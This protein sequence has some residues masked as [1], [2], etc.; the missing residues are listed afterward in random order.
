MRAADTVIADSTD[1]IGH[2]V[3]EQPSSIRHGRTLCGLLWDH[4]PCT[5]I[6]GTYVPGMR[7]IG[8]E[9]TCLLCLVENEVDD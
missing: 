2:L 8:S 4:G 1:G 3:E 9:A 7:E 6:N 5:N